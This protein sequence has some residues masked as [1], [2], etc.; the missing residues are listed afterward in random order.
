MLSLIAPRNLYIASASDNMWADPKAQYLALMA[1][2]PVYELY[3]L[4]GL[5]SNYKMPEIGEQLK[6]GRIGYHIR[7]GW[8]Y[9][10]RYDWNMFMNY[11]QNI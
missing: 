7:Q 11:F 8:H 3:N 6:D 10:S 9:L 2:N 1:T 5:I 4:Q